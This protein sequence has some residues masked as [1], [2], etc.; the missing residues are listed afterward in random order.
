[1]RRP[2]LL[3][4]LTALAIAGAGAAVIFWGGEGSDEA[5]RLRPDD[6]QLVAEGAR[7][8]AE[9][10]ASCHGPRLEGQADW[11]QRRA[12]GRLPAPPHDESGHS[13]HHPDALLFA[14][15][16]QGPAALVGQDY[17]SDM[18]AYEGVLSDA[19]ILAV[20]SYIKSRWPEEVRRRHDAI[21]AAAQ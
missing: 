13:W 19:E 4:T 8:Y 10:C 3:V 7:V 5:V 16:K 20:L 15:T 11:Q 2:L 1:M 18:P 12:D 17:Q 9:H 14:L 6:P 21:N